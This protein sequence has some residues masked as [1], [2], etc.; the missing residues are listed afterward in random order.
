MNAKKI[1]AWMY[2]WSLLCFAMV[3]TSLLLGAL[4]YRFLANRPLHRMASMSI[5]CGL[6]AICGIR[7]LC[8]ILGTMDCPMTIGGMKQTSTLVLASVILI[9]LLTLDVPMR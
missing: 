5:I 6:L 9:I 7:F 1:N 3:Y 8:C 2:H 4:M